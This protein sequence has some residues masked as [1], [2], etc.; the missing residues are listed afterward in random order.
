V[1]I[2][3]ALGVQRMAKKHAVIRKLSS[4]ETLGSTT[5]ICSDKTGTLTKNEMTVVKVFVNDTTIDVEGNGYQVDGRFLLGTTPYQHLN[6]EFLLKVGMLC[7]NAVHTP[8]NKIIGDPTEGALIVSSKKYGLSHDELKE[9]H[10]RLHELP[11]DS[12]RKM[13]STVHSFGKETYLLVKGAPDQIISRSTQFQLH[14]TVIPLTKKKKETL[15]DINEQFGQGALRVLAFAYK[16]I[17]IPPEKIKRQQIEILES[18]LIFIGM[19]GMRDPPRP[20]VYAA[21]KTCKEAGIRI[22]VVSGDYGITTKAIA[23]EL[24]IAQNQ[25]P[26]ITGDLLEKTTDAD[27]KTILQGEAIFARV[28]PEHKMRIVGLLKEMGEIVAVTGDGVNDAPAIKKADIGISMGITGTD[29]SKEASDMVLMD[30]SFATI[31][32]AVKEG[33]SIYIDITK[34]LKYVF[35]GNIGG[36]LAVF[37]GMILALFLHL[38]KGTLIFTSSHILWFNLLV[39]VLP[40][41]ALGI[42]PP[43]DDVMKK[44]PRHPKKRIITMHEFLHWLPVGVIIAMGTLLVFLLYHADHAKAV[45]MAFTTLVFFQMMNVFN[46]RSRTASIFSLNFFS[47]GFLLFVVGISVMLQILVVHLTFFQEIFKTVSL[48]LGDWGVVVLISSSVII[49]EELRKAKKRQLKSQA[50][51]F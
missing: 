45:T 38:P 8:E 11:F 37:F 23:Q 46:C 6:L 9:K 39:E 42:D 48:S 18:D 49:F 15:Q 41:L 50:Q 16:K 27:L 33:R 7:N 47:N 51:A 10:P 4:V 32:T 3:L 40:G 21:V 36:V 43:E 14:N 5:V 35:T 1:T 19:Q 24:G 13:M 12:T 44:Q 25:T 20:E 28:N 17:N 29:V 31:V 26:V 34:F 30:D 22:F 2:A